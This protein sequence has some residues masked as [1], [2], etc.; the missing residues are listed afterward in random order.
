MLTGFRGYPLRARRSRA[1]HL[2]GMPPNVHRLE[3]LRREALA[4]SQ[5]LSA[6]QQALIDALHDLQVE[7]GRRPRATARSCTR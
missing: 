1:D 3:T 6:G 2:A 4:A 7:R 5:G